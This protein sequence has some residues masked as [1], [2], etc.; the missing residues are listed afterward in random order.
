MKKTIVYITTL[1]LCSII[2]TSCG[3]RKGAAETTE[4]P[5][6]T[7]G[8]PKAEQPEDNLKELLAGTTSKTWHI[9]R[10][11]DASG[12]KVKVT[13]AE[14]DETLSIF[15]NGS[16]SIT[17]AEQTSTGTWSTEGSH[18]LIMHFEGKDVTE[19]F[20]IMD[21]SKE[22]IVLKAGDGSQMILK[23]D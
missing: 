9:A 11:V 8:T 7:I 1:F 21:I 10:Q 19:N 12:D 3:N 5:G 14:K 2:V 23:E 17:D 20:A 6:G 15:N 4:S 18:T 22:K 13:S 16:F